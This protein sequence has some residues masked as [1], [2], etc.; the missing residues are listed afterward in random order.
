MRVS[1]GK[2]GVARVGKIT[3]LETVTLP[4]LTKSYFEIKMAA[5]VVHQPNTSL[6]M[7]FPS[8]CQSPWHSYRQL[9]NCL[10]WEALPNLPGIHC[11]LLSSRNLVYPICTFIMIPIFPFCTMLFASASLSAR[12]WTPWRQGPCLMHLDI[13]AFSTAPST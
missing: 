1:W 5:W 9:G 2:A 3:G 11:F 12:P 4:Q 6:S 13:S 8:L 10:L 7:P